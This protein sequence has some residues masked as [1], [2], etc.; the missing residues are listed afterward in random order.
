MI[1]IGALVRR[2]WRVALLM[3]IAAA[4]ATLLT[5]WI[6]QLYDTQVELFRHEP[7]RGQLHL[8]AGDT[9]RG[10]RRQ[11]GGVAGTG[12]PAR[13][14]A[15]WGLVLAAV[16]EALTGHVTVTAVI[17]GV[18]VAVVAGGGA[19]LALGT[20]AG[21]LEAEEVERL[22]SAIG[23]DV[24]TIGESERRSDGELVIPALT[25]AGDGIAIKVHGRDALESRFASRI[26][27][28]V[29]YRDG[30]GTLTAPRPPGL[31]AET[32]ATLIAASHGARVWEVEAAGRPDRSADVMV[33]RTPGRRLSD[34]GDLPAD[35]V[36]AAWDALAALH[37]A[38]YAHLGLAPRA[39][40][41][42]PDGQVGLTDLRD[43]IAVPA[44]DQ[45]ATDEAQLLVTLAT[46]VGN[47]QAVRESI[48]LI[49]TERTMDLVPFLQPA[50]FGGELRREVR[51]AKVD[52]DELRTAAI[53]ETGEEEPVLAKLRRVSLGGLVQAAL[54]A[55]AFSAII[56]L[57]SGIDVN[58]LKQSLQDASVPLMLLAFLIAQTPRFGQAVST[59]GSV[60]ARLQFGPVYAMQ[61]ATSFMNLALPSAAAR[62]AISVRFFQRNGV[63]PATAVTSGL[64]DSLVGNVIQAVLLVL[65]LLFSPAA[66]DA[67]PAGDTSSSS[68]SSSGGTDFSLIALIV[69]L[70]V[71]VVLAFLVVPRLRR[72]AV[73]R[74]RAWWPEVRASLQPLRTGH[75][76]AQLIGGNLAAE[77]LFASALAVMAQR[78]RLA[79]LDRRRAVREPRLE[80]DRDGDPG[81]GWHRRR[82]GDPDRRPDRGRGRAR[83]RAFGITIAY[84]MSTFYLPPIWGW[85]AMRWLQKRRYL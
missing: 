4:V 81:A 33:L 28:A 45:I 44:P 57:L 1:A 52:I 13:R 32:L 18:M 19:R 22:V 64:I 61:L 14:L 80:P 66:L 62:M 26:W 6:T 36:P 39:V 5:W 41:A 9:C 82:R 42:L 73:S 38:G 79:D 78:V 51:A 55:L 40:V 25:T 11:R 74:L 68:S 76:L 53:K 17:G 60:P 2:R 50:A 43:A 15:I 31:V 83:R 21:H 35:L 54:L 7:R 59:L 56:S 29:W 37:A 48:G 23:V 47:Q 49:G 24:G 3:L 20:S 75:K 8:A 84:R 58:E 69:V 30:A 27:R 77:L 12:G 65:L 71:L 16:A 85:F 67:I 46:I 70:V 72:L 63:A 10:R 34:G